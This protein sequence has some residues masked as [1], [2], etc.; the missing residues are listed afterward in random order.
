MS[1]VRTALGQLPGRLESVGQVKRRMLVVS[2]V[3]ALAMSGAY[4][5]SRPSPP[6]SPF[7]GD[8]LRDLAGLPAPPVRFVQESDGTLRRLSPDEQKQL[9]QLQD[10]IRNFPAPSIFAGKGAK[11][12][13]AKSRTGG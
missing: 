5:V 1:V 12:G 13:S 10:L 11:A 2:V 6:A 4:V 3:A 9:A 8:E 7:S